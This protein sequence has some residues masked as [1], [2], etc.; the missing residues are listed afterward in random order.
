MSKRKE[1]PE[2]WDA[3]KTSEALGVS[4]ATLERWRSVQP[5]ELPFVKMGRRVMYRRADIVAFIEKR[6]VK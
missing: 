4:V 2:L 5:P 1:V 6:V 3:A